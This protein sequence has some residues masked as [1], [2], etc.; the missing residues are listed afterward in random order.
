M[1][2]RMTKD[3]LVAYDCSKCSLV[4]PR[5][6]TNVKFIDGTPICVTCNLALGLLFCNTYA[7]GKAK[8]YH[9]ERWEEVQAKRQERK[10]ARKKLVQEAVKK[11]KDIMKE[12]NNESVKDYK[13]GH[14]RQKV[15]MSNYDPVTK[16]RTY[17]I[18]KPKP[19]HRMRDGMIY[20]GALNIKRKICYGVY[21]KNGEL[22]D[23]SIR[24]RPED[25]KA[26]VIM[27]NKWQ[28][29]GVANAND[30]AAWSDMVKLGYR[31]VAIK[32]MPF[33]EATLPKLS[34]GVKIVN[35]DK[36]PEIKGI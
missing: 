9:R 3:K 4:Y 31:C 35:S 2:T 7:K 5:E 16:T 29:I 1:T 6:H 17:T 12:I 25:A 27:Y 23:H 26:A 36:K 8:H 21:S 18:Q 20:D 13:R 34:D 24:R 28:T 33:I 10:D 15:A 19:F 11:S 32:V 22:I 30:G 14:G